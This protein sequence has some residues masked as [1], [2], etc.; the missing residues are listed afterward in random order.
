MGVLE[1]LRPAQRVLASDLRDGTTAGAATVALIEDGH[2][3]TIGLKLTEIKA[4][5]IPGLDSY[6]E[7]WREKAYAAEI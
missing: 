5:A 6:H 2:L 1:Q 7:T 3:P 4:T